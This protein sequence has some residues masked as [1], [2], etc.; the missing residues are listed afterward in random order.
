MPVVAGLAAVHR[1]V[2]NLQEPLLSEW[3]SQALVA[4]KVMLV[5]SEDKTLGLEAAGHSP[6][7]ERSRVTVTPGAASQSRVQP[8]AGAVV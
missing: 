2:W 5:E 1:H 7:E 8:Q 3:L 6:A 4:D